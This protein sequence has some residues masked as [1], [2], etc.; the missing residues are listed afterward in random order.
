MNDK[1]KTIL[2]SRLLNDE[3]RTLQYIADTFGISRERVRQIE[4]NLL[5]KMKKYIEKSE[6]DV[7]DF[8]SES[9]IEQD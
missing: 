9:R 7:T 6:P 8:F 4:A 2:D 3:P 1:E 5:K